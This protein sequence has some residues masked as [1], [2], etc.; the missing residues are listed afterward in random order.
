MRRPPQYRMS[1]WDDFAAAAAAV[2]IKLV[3]D[4]AP[5]VAN[6]RKMVG[7]GTVSWPAT[8]DSLGAGVSRGC[9]GSTGESVQAAMARMAA[10]T[11]RERVRMQDLRNRALGTVCGC[12]LTLASTRRQE[13]LGLEA[14]VFGDQA[15]SLVTRYG[16]C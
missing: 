4:V 16:F 1:G 2:L 15:S 3:A 11:I 5:P 13:I 12:D 14:L 6:G 7:L 8:I 10:R 9:V